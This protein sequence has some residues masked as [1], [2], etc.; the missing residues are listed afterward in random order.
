MVVEGGLQMK[1]LHRPGFFLSDKGTKK[2]R[3]L[4][5]PETV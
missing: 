1:K 4:K 5:I 3:G 2:G